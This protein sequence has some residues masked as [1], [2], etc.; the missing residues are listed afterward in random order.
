MLGVRM[1]DAMYHLMGEYTSESE[2]IDNSDEKIEYNL[3]SFI[4]NKDLLM[5]L[6][7]VAEKI[8]C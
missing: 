6:L 2:N 5:E 1:D 8:R 4:P 7:Q 3:E